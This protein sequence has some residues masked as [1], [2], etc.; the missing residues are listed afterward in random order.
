ML[1]HRQCH[2]IHLAV[3]TLMGLLIRHRSALR[4]LDRFG[5]RLSWL[6]FESQH[7]VLCHRR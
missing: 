5:C 7:L 6:L 4:S 1:A 3:Q 2:W